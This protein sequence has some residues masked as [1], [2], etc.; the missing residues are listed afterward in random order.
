MDKAAL[1]TLRLNDDRALIFR[2]L[3]NGVEKQKIARTFRRSEK[4]VDDIFGFVIRKIRS[5]QLERMEPPI[6]E[7]TV[8]K[9]RNSKKSKLQCLDILPLL[10]LEK[11]PLYKRVVHEDLQLREDGSMKNAQ[12]LRELRP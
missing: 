1:L 12:I 5:R 2:N 7:D 3:L 10:N 6:L 9:L 11:D 8:E 4:D